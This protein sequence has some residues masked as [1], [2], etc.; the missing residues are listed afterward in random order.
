MCILITGGCG[1]IGVSLT[2]GLLERHKEVSLFDI[3]P[4]DHLPEDLRGRVKYIRGDITDWVEV[5]NAVKGHSI[6]SIFHLAG[7]LSAPSEANP[8]QS[9]RV[10]AEGTFYVLEAAR[11]FGV[12][13]VIF[14]SSMGTYG[15]TDDAIISDATAQV[16]TIMYGVTKVFDELLGRYYYNKF[17]LDFRGIRFPQVIGPGVKSGGFGQYNPGMIEAAALGKPYEV[18][19]PEDTA[20]PILYVKDAVNGLLQLYAAEASRIKTR[21]YNLG[22]ITPPPTAK[23]LADIIKRFAPSAQITFKPDPK[24]IEAV[25]VICKRIDGSNA[26]KEWGWKIRYSAEEM[27]KDFLEEMNLVGRSAHS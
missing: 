14:S 5:F 21:I 13:K 3:L 12:D 20:L 19:V 4:E 7:L 2:R 1:L 25:K 18:W 9:Y 8:W 11:F 17:G 24:A 23:D 10:N 22:Q 6:K 16:P 27:V 26:E 15:I